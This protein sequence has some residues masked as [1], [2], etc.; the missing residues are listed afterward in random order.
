MP[1]QVELVS[2]EGVLFEGEAA[3]VVARTVGGGDIAF[4]TGHVPF[5]GTLA[6]HPVKIVAEDGSAR[7]L[8]VHRGFVEV[9]DDHGAFLSDSAEWPADIDVPRAEAA[10]A[11]AQERLRADPED[12]EA[13][14][15]L[16]RAEVRLEVAAARLEATSG[17]PSTSH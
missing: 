4:L 6:V 5:I 11:R 12:E 14:A 8:A 10:R 16:V 1:L 9:S 7:V 13:K 2:P 15:A 3:M 17:R